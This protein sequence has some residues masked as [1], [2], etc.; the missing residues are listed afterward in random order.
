MERKQEGERKAEEEEETNRRNSKARAKTDMAMTPSV[1]EEANAL[2]A[3]DNQA[4]SN[5][6]SGK[7]E[8]GNDEGTRTGDGSAFQKRFLRHGD[9]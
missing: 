2:S 1:A 7:N 6:R 9:R 3:D 8:C 5:R 4:C